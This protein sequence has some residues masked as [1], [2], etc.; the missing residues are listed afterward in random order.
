MKDN[1]PKLTNPADYALMKEM[2]FEKDYNKE[3]EDPIERLERMEAKQHN[4]T[5]N[6]R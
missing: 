2:Y 3:E 5:N 6:A 1:R 4:K